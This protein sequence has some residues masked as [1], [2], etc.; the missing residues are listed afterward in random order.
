MHTVRGDGVAGIKQR[1]RDLSFNGVRNL[2]MTS[3]CGRIK[4][5]LES[6]T[7]RRTSNWLERLPEG[8]ITIWEDLTTRFLGQFFLPGRT[9][10]LRNDI[11][12]NDNDDMA[13]DDGINGTDTKMPVKEAEKET[14][15]QNGTKSKLIKRA[16]REETAEASS[17]QPI[18]YYLKHRINEK[19]IEELIDNHRFNDSLSGIKVG[20]VMRFLALG[21]HLEEIHVTWVHLEKK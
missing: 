5:D 14:E 21:W 1:R 3:G 19:L 9:A 11:L 4:E 17:S 18:G 7:W 6:S 16:E 8:S 2:A 20:K 10:K 13:A 12:M 15:V